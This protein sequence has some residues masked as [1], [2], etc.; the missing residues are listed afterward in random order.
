MLHDHGTSSHIF[1]QS[2][3]PESMTGDLTS[4]K[5]DDSVFSFRDNAEM[6]T[7]MKV[8]IALDHTE[9]SHAA[10]NC[11]FV[12]KIILFTVYNIILLTQMSCYTFR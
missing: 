5:Y 8:I 12:Y 9:C 11:K 6:D 1:P 7:T 3:N 10:F 2:Q 4:T